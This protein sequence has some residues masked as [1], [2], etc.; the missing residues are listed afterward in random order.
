MLSETVASNHL[1]RAERVQTVNVTVTTKMYE[2][3]LLK[4]PIHMCLLPVYLFLLIQ[5]LT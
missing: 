4:Y 3:I 1:R 2:Y 5:K